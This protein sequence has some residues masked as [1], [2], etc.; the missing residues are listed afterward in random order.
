M[1][2][3][4]F[5]DN[6]KI[7]L[8]IL[9]CGFN[10]SHPEYVDYVAE[11]EFFFKNKAELSKSKKFKMA[12]EG[13]INSFNSVLCTTFDIDCNEQRAGK[14][15]EALLIKRFIKGINKYD[16][17]VK[18]IFNRIRKIFPGAIIKGICTTDESPCNDIPI[19]LCMN[20]KR[21]LYIIEV[22]STNW[23]DLSYL[24]DR[25][26]TGPCSMVLVV[27]Y[28]SCRY[29][30]IIGFAMI[31]SGLANRYMNNSM[32]PKNGRYVHRFLRDSG[33]WFG[34]TPK[35]HCWNNN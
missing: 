33:L 31:S 12:V 34:Q 11:Q 10:F 25:C 27:G 32:E 35:K 5:S 6:C 8:Q 30:T 21:F 18:K 9:G 22:K 16:P 1:V 2:L 3:L 4:T 19:C 15:I 7:C 20:N 29:D 24:A 14:I 26:L 23:N 17:L 28:N 13:L